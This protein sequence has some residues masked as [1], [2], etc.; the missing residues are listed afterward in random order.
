MIILTIKISIICYMFYA[1]GEVGM[2]FNFWQKWI[3]RLPWYVRNPLGGCYK[4]LVGQSIFHYYWITHL[5]SY[6]IIDQLFYPAMGILIVTL[7]NYLYDRT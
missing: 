5:H 4:C 1:L 3:N 7:L 6:S 2:I